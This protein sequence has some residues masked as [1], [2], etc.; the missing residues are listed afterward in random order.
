MRSMIFFKKNTFDGKVV[1]GE[2]SSVGVI[3]VDEN[4][5]DIPL[6]R[7]KAC[8]IPDD[9]LKGGDGSAQEALA[10]LIRQNPTVGDFLL[11]FAEYMSTQMK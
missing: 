4:V 9:A 7:E 11:H 6:D 8:W 1:P 5:H 2:F 10:E 3:S